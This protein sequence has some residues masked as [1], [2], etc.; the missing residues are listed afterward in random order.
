MKK[1]C[2]APHTYIHH[3]LLCWLGFDKVLPGS[4][5]YDFTA[6]SDYKS[7]F[8][9]RT[10]FTRALQGVFR[11]PSA[12]LSVTGRSRHTVGMEHNC[13]V[14]IATHF[15]AALGLV[16]NYS[17][18]NNSF[19]SLLG[20]LKWVE[21]NIYTK[22]IHFGFGFFFSLI[23]YKWVICFSGIEGHGQWALWWW[24]GGWTRWS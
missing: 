13:A 6:M 3:K 21:N 19:F 4:R 16:W 22:P 15:M 5:C 20:E 18:A 12:L 14:P 23:K 9:P 2:C 11:V 10:G 24:V 17:W 8:W 1:L 7:F